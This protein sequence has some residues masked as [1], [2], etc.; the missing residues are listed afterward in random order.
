[1]NGSTRRAHASSRPRSSPSVSH[2]KRQ[3]R[4]HEGH[5]LQGE[6]KKIKPP[7]FNGEHRKGEE[8]EAWLLEIKKHFQ[9]HDYP[10]RVE[11][12]IATYHLQEKETMWLD[13]R[14]Q[15]KH[16]DEK[17]VSW[18]KFKGYFQDKYLSE[19]YYE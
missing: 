11:T 1:M 10:S 19:H 9:L 6:L 4:M 18:R 14:K 13:Q 12:R 8:V 15:A 3:R 2:V 7:T 17:R 5:I 16:L